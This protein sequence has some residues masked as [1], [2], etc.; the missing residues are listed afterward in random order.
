[1][2]NKDLNT[3]ELQRIRRITNLEKCDVEKR[4]VKVYELEKK[5]FRGITIFVVSECSWTLQICQPFRNIL[6][7]LK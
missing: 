4:C 1:M 3:L 5:Y 7:D 2:Q 6:V